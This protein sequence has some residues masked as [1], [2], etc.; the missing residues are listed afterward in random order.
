MESHSIGQL[1]PISAS[2]IIR[3]GDKLCENTT[4]Y[5][6][7]PDVYLFKSYGVFAMIQILRSQ[8]NYELSSLVSSVVQREVTIVQMTASRK[9]EPRKP[10]TASR[11]QARRDIFRNIFGLKTNNII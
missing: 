7:S 5:F 10:V 3:L 11:V 2:K 1:G 8:S 4:F 9:Q 6:D